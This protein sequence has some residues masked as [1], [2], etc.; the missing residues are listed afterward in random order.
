MQILN[1]ATIDYSVGKCTQCNL[2]YDIFQGVC[3][4][5]N[6]SVFG[7]SNNLAC[8]TCINGY[9]LTNNICQVGK[10]SSLFGIVCQQCLLGYYLSNGL[11]YANNCQTFDPVVMVCKQCNNNYELIQGV[12]IC[13]PSNC[14][15]YDSSLSCTLCNNGYLL[16]GSICTMGDPNCIKWDNSNNC[17]T[18]ISSSFIPVT[19][20]CI[21]RV[22]G[23]SNYSASGC[24]DCLPQ[25]S[26]SNGLCSAKYCSV[27]STPDICITCRPQFQLQPDGSCT[28]LYCLTFN[29][30]QWACTSCQP[31]YQLILGVCFTY[32][33]TNYSVSNFNCL[34]CAAGFTLLQNTCIFS[35][36]LNSTQFTCSNCL[37]NFNLIN[38][39]CQ[40][41]Q[42]N[43]AQYDF[44]QFVCKQCANGYQLSSSGLC[45][46]SFIDP[47][48]ISFNTNG[49]CAQCLP[50]FNFNPNSLQC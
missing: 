10:C 32:N 28:P 25:Y 36:C 1:C 38:G 30:S 35:N 48:C 29:Q 24:T 41:P 31:R 23:C 39:V 22:P 15:N 4:V 2:G 19:N 42:D 46:S 26:W 43:C 37:P 50:N 13:K 33:C 49:Q 21:P 34:S 16:Q 47:Y 20:K 6:C 18:C 7:G 40:A 17:L 45:Q 44:Q 8:V 5:S 11:C 9:Y 14:A 27:S 12:G 3:R